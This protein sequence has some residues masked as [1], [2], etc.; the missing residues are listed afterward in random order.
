M[1][2]N[3]ISVRYAK[4]LF[5]AALEEKKA[6]K[7]NNDIQLLSETVIIPEFRSFLENPVVFP[8]KKQEVFNAIFKTKVD[9]LTVN[10]FRLLTNNKREFYLKAIARNFSDF[11]RKHYGIKSVELITVFSADKKLKDDVS[12]IIEKEFN[13]KVELSDQMNPDIIG[14]F[15]LTVG[16]MQY[17]T[18]VS[19]KL[20]K[21]KKELLKA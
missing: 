18:S 8:S 20:K 9:N 12:K 3:R 13:T 1:N 5:E 21:I 4:A 10:F 14:G 7:I 15:I 19:A 6:E 16:G 2:T 17:D 11:Y